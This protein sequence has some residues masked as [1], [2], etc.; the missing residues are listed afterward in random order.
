M[1]ITKSKTPWWYLLFMTIV[2][3]PII[4]AA[5]VSNNYGNCLYDAKD[6]CTAIQ[7]CISKDTTR[8]EITIL[9]GAVTGIFGGITMIVEV[10]N[11]VRSRASVSQESYVA[12]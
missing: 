5:I 1:H 9:A 12:S 4:W 3:F 10:R 7:Q 2:S 6:N 11:C 8:K